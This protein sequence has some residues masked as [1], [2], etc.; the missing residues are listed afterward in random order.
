MSERLRTIARHVQARANE[1]STGMRRRAFALAIGFTLSAHLV[2]AQEPDPATEATR[3]LL[4][5]E[6]DIAASFIQAIVANG[7]RPTVAP[8]RIVIRSDPRLSVFLGLPADTVIIGQWELMPPMMK[9]AIGQLSPI[10]GFG[11]DGQL[12]FE[13]AFHKFFL[14]HE[15][16]HWV[17]AQG[18]VLSKPTIPYPLNRYAFELEANRLA[19]AYWRATDTAYATRI[20]DAFR[21]V[22]AAM[23]N[24]VP[25]GQSVSTYFTNNYVALG[26]TPAYAW[27]QARLIVEAADESPAP[28]LAQLLAEVGALPYR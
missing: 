22:Y 18:E 25:A 13:T 7:F 12:F 23:P 6:N 26:R 16:G 8:P 10:A 2:D 9:E 21:R 15:I 14:V 19:L 20:T 1:S 3:S 28:S 5:K 17:Q 4:S 24:P 27:F 11:T